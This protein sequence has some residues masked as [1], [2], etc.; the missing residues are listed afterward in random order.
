MNNK[1]RKKAEQA[2]QARQVE[3]MRRVMEADSQESQHPTAT[4]LGLMFG[5]AMFW[6][7]VMGLAVLVYWGVSKLLEG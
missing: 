4:K 6:V 1:E 5:K 3:M 7:M 2:N